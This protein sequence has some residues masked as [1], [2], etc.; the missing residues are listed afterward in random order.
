MYTESQTQG[1]YTG[2]AAKFLIARQKHLS[3]KNI[4]MLAG[5]VILKL[6][7][8]LLMSQRMALSRTFILK[9]APLYA[10]EATSK[11][12]TQQKKKKSIFD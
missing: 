1:A 8:L 5:D 9:C 11:Q 6:H 12:P 4:N 3:D 7:H 2:R 10:Q